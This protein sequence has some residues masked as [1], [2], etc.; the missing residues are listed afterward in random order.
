MPDESPIDLVA[1]SQRLRMISDP[2][3][4]RILSLLCARG[5]MHV[6]AIGEAVGKPESHASH[7]LGLL[8]LAGLVTPRRVGH[9]V[10]YSITPGWGADLLADLAPLVGVA[11]LHLK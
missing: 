2:T 5:A 11:K 9:F 8:R 4:L 1:I 7:H 10:R 3:R 6:A